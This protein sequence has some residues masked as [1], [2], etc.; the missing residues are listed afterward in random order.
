MTT[1]SKII[2]GLQDAVAHARGDVSAAREQDWVTIVKRRFGPGFSKPCVRPD[3]IEC[4]MWECQV[5]DRCRYAEP[6]ANE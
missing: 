2:A 4:A 6:A 1:G 3:V 5:K